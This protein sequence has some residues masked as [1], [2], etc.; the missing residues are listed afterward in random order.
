VDTKR[1]LECGIYLK[2]NRKLATTIEN[3]KLVIQFI[4]MIEESRYLV[5]HEWN[6]RNVLRH[7]LSILLEWRKIYWKQR[8]TIKW[9][10]QGDACNKFFHANATIRHWQ[11]MITTLQ[12][13]EGNIERKH[14]DK[15]NLFMGGI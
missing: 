14:E 13:I 7:H 12:D 4:N 10:T 5:I 15:A 11:N 3:T 8:D 9:V 2:V 6:F 1:E